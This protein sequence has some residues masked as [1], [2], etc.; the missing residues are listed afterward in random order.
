[1]MW[2]LVDGGR[3]YTGKIVKKIEISKIKKHKEETKVTRRFKRERKK[4]RMIKK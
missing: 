1:M 4:L 3:S 2:L